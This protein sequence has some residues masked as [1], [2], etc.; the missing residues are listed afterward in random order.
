MSSQILIFIILLSAL[1]LFIWGRWR[2]D[3]VGAMALL[4]A[5]LTGVVPFH[6]AI[7]G[8]DNA[9]VVTVACVMVI[10]QAI[11][12]SG[13][14]D[15]I[16]KI[17]DKCT[18]SASIHVLV[19]TLLTAGFS[20]F[21]NNIGAI[22]LIMPIA[23]QSATKT[24]RSPAMFLMPMAFASL[25]GGM[26][27]L[28]GTPPNLIVSNFRQTA[29]GEPFGMFSYTPV[30][31]TVAIVGIIYLGFIGW[32]LLPKKRLQ[33]RTTEEL[34]QI[35]D[36]ITEI[37][38]TE[39]S[40]I[41]GSTLVDF[42]E[43]TN[44]E[45]AILGL[46][47]HNMKWVGVRPRHKII[48]GDILIIRASSS[49][50]EKVL[51]TAQLSL[52]GHE[53]ISSDTL[54]SEEV[55]VMEV[56]VPPDSNLEARSV[57]HLQLRNRYRL[58]LLAISRRGIPFTE[59]LRDVALQT[60]DVLL[61]QGETTSLNDTMKEIG[62]LPLAGRGIEIGVRRWTLLPILLF[63][64][65]IILVILKIL[66]VEIAFAAT[67][68]CM[69][70]LNIVPVRKVY[71][72]VDWSI[73]ILLGTLI[74][75]GNALVDT[76]A[77]QTISNAIIHVAGDLPPF[78]ILAIILITTM[79]LTDVINHAATAVLMAPLAISVAQTLHY[80]IDPFLVAVAIG[81]SCS[82]LTPIG[83]QSNTLVLGPGGYHFS[84]Y[85][86]MGMPLVLLIILISVPVIGLIWPLQ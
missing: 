8:F 84:D 53:P 63:A 18:R 19:L 13:F 44:R 24:Q 14:I 42:I 29:L 70:V 64:T 4:V 50:L 59:R 45:I 58:N 12:N 37:K 28:I 85:W 1:A 35:Q 27:T 75:V 43:S 39:K 66:P 47:R 22:A 17:L 38:V 65:A 25:L 3:V 77:T 71:Q 5:L 31:L 82:F 69:I 51:Q 34:F 60:G 41:I 83:H 46:I 55:G 86:R 81:A 80:H 36:Y 23:L 33:K 73:I 7:S 40:T 32:R 15:H 10:T 57:K 48:L 9:A 11:A 21:M 6:K 54:G 20:A 56:V 72:S 76:G 26:T 67:V 68:L 62:F 78:V 16:M 30:G 74:P 52:V 49:T 2:Y 79:L 61:I